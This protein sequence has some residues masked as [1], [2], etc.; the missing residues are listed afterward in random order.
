[1]YKRKNQRLRFF[2]DK[3]LDVVIWFRFY[4]TVV[5]D[6][7]GRSEGARPTVKRNRDI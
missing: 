5:S 7:P 3:F 2:D 4:Y 6:K 1:M